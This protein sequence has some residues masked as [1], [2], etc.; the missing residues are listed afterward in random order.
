MQHVAASSLMT[1]HSVQNSPTTL[2]RVACCCICWWSQALVAAEKLDAV[3]VHISGINKVLRQLK[4]QPAQG[5]AG[6]AAA[7]EPGAEPDAMEV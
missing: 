2:M 4:Q 5:S 3:S 6:N 7:T 1:L